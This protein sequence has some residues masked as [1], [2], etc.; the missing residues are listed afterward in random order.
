V[1]RSEEAEAL[2]EGSA[3]RNALEELAFLLDD[4]PGP[5][6]PEVVHER[7][8]AEVA[9]A[10]ED[11]RRLEHAEACG[12]CGRPLGPRTRGQG[13]ASVGARPRLRVLARF[14]GDRCAVGPEQ[15][16]TRRALKTA[17]VA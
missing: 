5:G 3:L 10:R 16:V 6:A 13:A 14:T 17:Y 7:Y 9:E 2:P 12:I 4:T 11:V 8:A 15:R 1:T